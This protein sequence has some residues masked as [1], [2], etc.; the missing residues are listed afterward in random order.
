[1]GRIELLVRE[2]KKYAGMPWDR[3]LAGPQKVWFAVYP[4]DEERRLR[5]RINTFELA[6]LE[7]G[8]T[9]IG[10]E[11][12]NIFPEWMAKQEY[13]ESYFAD[14]AAMQMLLQEDFRD[15]VAEKIIEAL[16]REG[17]NGDTVVAIYG[18][19]SLFGLVKLSEVIER[20]TAKIRG[21]LLV[22]FPGEYE[23]DLY[24][25]L[26]SHTGWDYL[27]VPILSAGGVKK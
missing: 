19:S 16:S 8:H 20:V 9:W 17:T 27:A 12:T 10:C 5:F 1:M 23:K 24:S 15:C 11:L 4:P 3:N 26:N 2:Y 21:R 18:V 14:P 13:R 7:V 22:F 6:T 25:L